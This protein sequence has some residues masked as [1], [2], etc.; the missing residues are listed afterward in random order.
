VT[1]SPKASASE[2]LGPIALM[3]SRRSVQ[4]ILVAAYQSAGFG[5]FE[6]AADVGAVGAWYELSSIAKVPLKG[7]FT[8]TTNLF[9]VKP[10]AG[11]T[12][13][14]FTANEVGL[15]GSYAWY[16]ADPATAGGFDLP[17]LKRAVIVE[18][19]E[20]RFAQVEANAN[21][22]AA[23]PWFDL[24]ATFTHRFGARV[25]GRFWYQFTRYV[26]GIGNAHTLGTRW[27]WKV[28]GW[29]RLWVGLS[30]QYDQLEGEPS[31]F[32]GYGTLGGE[33]ATD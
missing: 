15:R 6:W 17:E 9:L 14:L 23:P 10:S 8:A 16:S 32:S 25:T 28:K 11:L 22:S 12:F 4:G 33:L 13:T 1:F 24:R 27:I 29:L 31:F 3:S 5:D 2:S 26:D 18:Q 7:T 19:A 21:F 30:L 20:A